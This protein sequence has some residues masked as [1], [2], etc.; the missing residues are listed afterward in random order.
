MS[1][2]F[3]AAAVV[4]SLMAKKRGEMRWS[5]L[6]SF[7][8]RTRM[9]KIEFNPSKVKPHHR[10]TTTSLHSSTFYRFSPSTHSATM[11]KAWKMING[12]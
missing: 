12:R 3:A 1:L 4:A 2:C 7:V 6:T 5:Q 8:N 11:K 9:L 10:S